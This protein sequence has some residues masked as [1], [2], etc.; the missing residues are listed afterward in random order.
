[1]DLFF[2]DPS[3]VPLPADE[4]RIRQLH[5][6]PWADGRRVRV[7][8]EVD[9]FQKRPS[10]DLIITDANGQEVAFASVIESMG[11][12]MELTMHL[13][14]SQ[15]LAPYTL[16]AVLYYAAFSQPDPEGSDPFNGPP[17]RMVIDRREIIIP[18]SP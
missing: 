14:G 6:E 5:A 9:P 10:V 16:Q 4:V 17:E 2:A 7:Y 1:M 15:P 18:S 12:K 13:R 8:L 3:E 11:R